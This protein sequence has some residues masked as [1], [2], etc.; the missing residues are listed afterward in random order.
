M[1]GTTMAKKRDDTLLWLTGGAVGL[2]VG[3]YF[4]LKS[5]AETPAG[6]GVT[7]TA[8]VAPIEP[9]S[10]FPTFD[11]VALRFDEVKEL[12]RMGY[13]EPGPVKVELDTLQTA[14]STFG[15]TNVTAVNEL[16][17]DIDELRD[18]VDQWLIDTGRVVPA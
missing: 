12:W 17:A 8:P 9:P 11:S 1:E 15:G 14:A 4:L 16:I 2:G 3:L 5:A 13:L 6:P 7:Q 10:A 18:V